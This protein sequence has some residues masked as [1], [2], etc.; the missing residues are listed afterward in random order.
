MKYKVLFVLE[1]FEEGV[2]LTDPARGLLVEFYIKTFSFF[3]YSAIEI[4]VI[5]CKFLLLVLSQPLENLVLFT[6]RLLFPSLSLNWL[7][8]SSF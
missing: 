2:V 1:F 8:S 6:L 5:V 7:F 4:L 3:V